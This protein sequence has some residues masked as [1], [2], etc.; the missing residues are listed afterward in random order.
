MVTLFAFWVYSIFLPLELCTA[1]FH[2][3]FPIYLLGM[4]FVTMGVVSFA[5]GLVHKP[6]TKGVFHISETL[7]TLTGS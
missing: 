7:C 6:A 5:T 2:G 1:W 3:G 4:V